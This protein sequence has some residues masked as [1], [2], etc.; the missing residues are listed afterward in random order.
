MKIFTA[1]LHFA[2]GLGLLTLSACGTYSQLRPADLLEPGR[3]EVGGGIA[4]NGTVGA[5]VFTGSYGLLRWLELGMQY[6]T[7]SG[8]VH[9]RVEITRSGDFPVALSLLFGAGYAQM[10]ES[11][12]EFK[13]H[14]ALV[15]GATLG[16]RWNR[17]EPYA[18]YRVNYLPDSRSTIQSLKGGLRFY[19][20]PE[21]IGG[22]EG[23]VV[24]HHAALTL[25]EF[26]I[27]LGYQF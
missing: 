9:A 14:Q 17:W 25:G 3:F 19:I 6:E 2:M 10:M 15:A 23:G 12:D 8:N 4:A 11:L 24:V 1:P 5:P 7:Y 18:G 13:V 20:T 16:R 26:A 21:V 27:F 22:G